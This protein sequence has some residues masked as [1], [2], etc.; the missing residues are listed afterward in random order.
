M[1]MFDREFILIYNDSASGCSHQDLTI[2]VELYVHS[3][4]ICCESMHINPSPF[5]VHTVERMKLECLKVEYFS[6]LMSKFWSRTIAG[7][8]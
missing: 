5:C 3:L 6:N 7:S 8:L 1:Y 4:T 2:T